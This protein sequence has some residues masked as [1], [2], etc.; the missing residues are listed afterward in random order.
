MSTPTLKLL[1]IDVTDQCPLYCGHCSNSS[2]PLQDRHFPIRSLIEILRESKKLGA[3]R[4]VLSGGEPL[5]YPHLGQAISEA[6]SL[7]LHTTLFTT[8]IEDRITRMPVSTE[9]WSELRRLG[10]GAARFS[11]Y[12]GPPNREFHNNVVR[13]KP[14]V[15]DAFGVNESAIRDAG[16]VGLNTEL[17]FVPC[18]V[19]A[20]DLLDIYSWAGELGCASLHLQMPTY[21]GRNAN[22][23]TMNLRYESELQL[24]EIALKLTIN[25][26]GPAFHISRFWRSRW[27]I[28]PASGCS[29][30]I[31]QLIIRTDGSISP[32]NACKYGGVHPHRENVLQ[33]S[34][35]SI[36]VS[37]PSLLEI[38]T[39]RIEGIIPVRCE[40][41]L[42]VSPRQASCTA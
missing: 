12:A 42:A 28:T 30:N 18:G 15:G 3:E 17:H 9:R 20:P 25:S 32:C 13:C 36:W 16:S 6:S 23:A 34:L 39:S 27:G 33:Q 26:G 41:V 21:Q 1:Q 4:I 10:L 14:E 8:G 24:K 2:G 22:G 19:N 31:E 5:R 7:D 11:I 29:A 35:A 38:R 37:S 40:A